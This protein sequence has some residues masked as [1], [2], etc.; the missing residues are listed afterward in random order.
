MSSPIWTRVALSSEFRSME[1][2]CWR[3]VEAQHRVS[4]VKLTDTLAEHDLLEQLIEQTKPTLPVDCRHLDYLLATPFRYGAIYPQGSRFR[5]AGRT[6]G[7]FYAAE[8]PETALAEL[9]FYRLLFFAE[10]PG[11]PWPKNPAEYTAFSAQIQTAKLL[12][13]TLP[14]L[15]ADL[16]I[17]Q[18]HTEYHGCQTFA[19]AARSADADIIRYT[20]VRDPKSRTNLAIL[21]CRAF[22]K[23]TVQSQHTWR[24]HF[25]RSGIRA[26]CEFPKRSVEFPKG[27]MATDPRIQNM[28]WNRTLS[29]G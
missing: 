12:D 7:V 16:S 21:Q 22:A 1:G 2:L 24:L 26:L 15:N 11:T 29:A 5:R 4:T 9:V 27:I 25:D 18:A 3:I 10:S 19:D 17:W 23:A 14:P 6:D 13:L 28:N 8:H 20:S